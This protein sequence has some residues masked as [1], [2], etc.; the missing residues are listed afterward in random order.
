MVLAINRDSARG[1]NTPHTFSEGV[2]SSNLHVLGMFLP[3]FVK[4]SLIARFGVVAIMLT[5]AAPC[6]DTF[7]EP[8]RARLRPFASLSFSSASLHVLS[9]RHDAAPHATFTE[10]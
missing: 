8:R 1:L 2:S 7:I 9:G 6:W 5:G 4:G 3:S 10:R